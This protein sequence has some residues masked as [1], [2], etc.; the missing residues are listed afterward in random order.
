M[1]K[2]R[3]SLAEERGAVIHRI[4]HLK[5]DDV[6]NGLNDTTSLI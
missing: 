3:V 2:V 1:L 6:A 4:N 5:A